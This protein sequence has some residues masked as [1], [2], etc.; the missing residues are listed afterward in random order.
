M[1]NSPWEEYPGQPIGVLKLYNYLPLS[2][3]FLPDHGA[4]EIRVHPANKDAELLMG[5]LEH[6]KVR[7]WGRI[8]D[9]GGGFAYEIAHV[10]LE[11]E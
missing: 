5:L 10:R 2:G 6:K 3:K 7:I 1:K 9:Q 4:W 11:K 8:V